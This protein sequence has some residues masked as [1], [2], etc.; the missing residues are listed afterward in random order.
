MIHY[1]FSVR[2]LTEEIE[3]I[4]SLGGDG[5]LLDTITLVRDKKFL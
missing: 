1:F 3:F 4:I 5:T 2:T